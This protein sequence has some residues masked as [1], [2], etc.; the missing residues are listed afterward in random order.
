MR[1]DVISVVLIVGLMFIVGC[2]SESQGTPSAES[3]QG[4]AGDWLTLE[5]KNLNSGE[6]FKIA[7]FAGKKVL[8]ESFAVWCPLCTKQQQR[9]KT[10]HEEIG[11]DVISVSINTDPNE[12]ESIVTSHTQQHGFDW[13]YAIAPTAVT[14]SLIDQFG[15]GVVNAPSVP[16]I[17]VCEDQSSRMLER[18]VKSV[19]ELKE[20][21]VKGC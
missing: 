4:T 19:A 9:I 7:D 10:L 18:G 1:R 14:Q 17:M 2:S 13:H 12:D 15:V 8:V 11:D 5:M 16:V 21:L 20:E 6:N 3:D